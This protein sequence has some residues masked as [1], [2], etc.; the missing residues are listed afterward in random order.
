MTKTNVIESPGLIDPDH[1][2]ALILANFAAW[3]AEQPGRRVV[4]TRDGA[5]YRCVLE[6]RRAARGGTLQESAAQGAHIA[7]FDS[8]VAP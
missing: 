7:A 1:Q 4:L 2:A 8:E 6:E 5:A 3:L